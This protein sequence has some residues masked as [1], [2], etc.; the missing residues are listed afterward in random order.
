MKTSKKHTALHEMTNAEFQEKLKQEY[1]N[2]EELREEINEII[3]IFKRSIA[4]S[5]PNF[6]NRDEFIDEMSDMLKGLD[7][8]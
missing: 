4:K 8:K 5:Y 2:N 7:V 3:G 1:E 6:D